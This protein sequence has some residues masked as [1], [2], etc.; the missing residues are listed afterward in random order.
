MTGR[1]LLLGFVLGV[2]GIAGGSEA[3]AFPVLDP[4]HLLDRTMPDAQF[5]PVGSK[6]HGIR[7]GFDGGHKGFH[8]RGF[9]KGFHGHGFHKGFHGHRFDRGFP[10]HHLFAGKR[11]PHHG[12][13]FR[14]R[15]VDPGFS[16]GLRFRHGDLFVRQRFAGPGF[17]FGHRF[18]N[19][20]SI[21]RQRFA[22]PG[23]FFD[24]RFGHGGTGFFLG[25]RLR[26]RS[27]FFDRH[28]DDRWRR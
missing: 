14:Q 3:R 22:G 12:V 8:G 7:R 28:F 27:L 18:G 26:H 23:L 10:R 24:H 1:I 17:F 5:L 25:D 9:H 20:G 13:F 19:G 15:F 16:L 6:H 4:A 2:A 21:V 11:L